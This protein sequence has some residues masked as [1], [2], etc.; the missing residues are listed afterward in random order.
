MSRQLFGLGSLV[1]Q[2]PIGPDVLT[3]GAYGPEA[4]LIESAIWMTLSQ[5]SSANAPRASAASSF[6]VSGA[7]RPALADAFFSSGLSSRGVDMRLAGST[8]RCDLFIED[9][10]RSSYETDDRVQL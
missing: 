6:A 2:V 3:G 10:P 5:A 9:C 4:V 7:W 8:Q 1:S